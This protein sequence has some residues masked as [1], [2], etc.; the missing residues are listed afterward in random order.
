MSVFLDTVN[1]VS[2]A[3]I[4][5]VIIEIGKSTLLD[6]KTIAI[7]IMS[8]VMTFYF[9]HCFHNFRRCCVRLHPAFCLGAPKYRV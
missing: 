9:K 3:I 2:V 4:L 7:A 6:A 8:F 5:S 1:I